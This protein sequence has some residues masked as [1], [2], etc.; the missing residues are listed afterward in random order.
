MKQK[1]DF[2]LKIIVL[3][4]AGFTSILHEAQHN[5]DMVHIEYNVIEYNVIY[6]QEWQIVYAHKRVLFW[7]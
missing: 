4:H 1:P 6:G 2:V 5:K 7:C 3:C